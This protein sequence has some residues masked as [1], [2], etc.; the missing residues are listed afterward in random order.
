MILTGG[1]PTPY[2]ATSATICRCIRSATGCAIFCGPLGSN[3]VNGECGTVQ[4]ECPIK[5][6]ARSL[7]VLGPTSFGGRAR[8]HNDCAGAPGRHAVAL[9]C[10][11]GDK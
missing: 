8:L 1:E 3:K 6:S 5:N 11:A 7:Q 9:L 10:V 2:S 4:P